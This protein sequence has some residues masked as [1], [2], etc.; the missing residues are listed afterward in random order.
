[1]LKIPNENIKK[2]GHTKQ[3][4]MSY[5]FFSLRLS[6]FGGSFFLCALVSLWDFSFFAP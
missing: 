6:A 3:S 1:M 4:G 5:H 2:I